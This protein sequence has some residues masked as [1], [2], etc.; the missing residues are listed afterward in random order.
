[1]SS[2]A[3][4]LQ[5]NPGPGAS[6]T[7][8]AH[9]GPKRCTGSGQ[10]TQMEPAAELL[11]LQLCTCLGDLPLGGPVSDAQVQSTDLLAGTEL[12]KAR[13]AQGVGGGHV[14]M[15]RVSHTIM[16]GLWL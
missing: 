6:T 12:R 13:E 7:K 11:L 3:R 5:T 14:K 10:A 8:P 9:L 2:P 1:M 4:V 16:R 15:F